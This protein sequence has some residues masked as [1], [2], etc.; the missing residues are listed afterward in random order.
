MGL[1]TYDLQDLSKLKEL[2]RKLAYEDL[3]FYRSIAHSRL[4]KD[5]VLRRKLE[6]SRSH[7]PTA[8][9]QSWSN[10]LWGSSSDQT[11]STGEPFDSPMSEQQR[12]ELYAVV[13]FDEKKAN[14]NA[15]Q[16]SETI[17]MRVA[18]TLQKGSFGLRSDTSGQAEDILSVMFDV[19]HANVIQRPENFEAE[20]SLGSFGIVEGTTPSSIHP[21]IVQVKGSADREESNPFFYLKFE[22]NPLDERADNALT[23]KMRHMEI[24]Y[25]RGYVEAVYRFFR[26][27]ESRL[28]SL[29]ALLVSQI[30]ACVHRF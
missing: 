15:F 29:E 8:T 23:V 20:I 1:T 3:R 14:S 26:P 25:Y 7:K 19:F 24:V 6:E 18:A 22:K 28:E 13:E 27:P 4:R 10:W 2:E 17:K 21:Q 5:A 11:Q 30:C 12:K 9:K 16:D